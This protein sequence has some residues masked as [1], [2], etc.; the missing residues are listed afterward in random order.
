MAAGA[1]RD[2]QARAGSPV[3]TVALQLLGAVAGVTALMTFAGG[4][5]LWL[6]FDELAIGSSGGSNNLGAPLVGVAKELQRSVMVTS[7]EEGY[8]VLC[9]LGL[10]VLLGLAAASWRTTTAP[11]HVR[12]AWIPAAVLVLLL[13]DYQWSGATAFLRG[14][15]EAGLLSTILV[16]GAPARRLRGTGLRPRPPRR[17]AGSPRWAA[18]FVPPTTAST[19]S[20]RAS[21]TSCSSSSVRSSTTPSSA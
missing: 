17:R 12:I 13:N 19:T 2:A 15:T 8:R 20:R 3:V 21:T 10:F 7:G 14:S 18:P 5:M 6:R 4:A 11:L 16:L 9:I 1:A